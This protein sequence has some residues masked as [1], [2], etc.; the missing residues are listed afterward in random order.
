MGKSSGICHNLV[1]G[2]ATT[3]CGPT[4]SGH[5]QGMI[6]ALLPGAAF[7]AI[8][9]GALGVS[10]ASTR[11]PADSSP[12]IEAPSKS[13]IADNESRSAMSGPSTSEKEAPATEWK[14]SS[15]TEGTTE[16]PGV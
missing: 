5:G 1:G 12:G 8:S 9:A 16:F 14:S 10:V 2:G 3:G 15:A 13:L 11:G 4:E 6:E 7:G